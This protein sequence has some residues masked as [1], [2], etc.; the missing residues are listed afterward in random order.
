[1]GFLRWSLSESAPVKPCTIFC[2]ACA[3]PSMRPT[4][5]PSAPSVWVRNVGSTG[6]CIS[7][8][9][10]AKKLANAN[11]NVFS[12]SPEN[13][14]CEAVCGVVFIALTLEYPDAR[15]YG[16]R[17][18]T[19][20]AAAASVLEERHEPEVHVQLGVNLERH[21]MCGCRAAEPTQHPEIGRS[22]Q[23]SRPEQP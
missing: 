6:Y 3:H 22:A 4:M 21:P 20:A 13:R 12:E 16:A 5:V 19:G 1:M 8:D 15:G 18:A 11:K 10:S 2:S 7:V 14:V 23:G 17:R 9:T